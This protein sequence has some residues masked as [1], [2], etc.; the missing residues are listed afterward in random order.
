[1]LDA[2][3]KPK[4]CLVF[5]TQLSREVWFLQAC[6][7]AFCFST[8]GLWLQSSLRFLKEI[9]SSILLQSLTLQMRHINSA[10]NYL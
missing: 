5:R 1:M 4:Q 8:F 6:N 2:S 3:T 7:A 10:A 9:C